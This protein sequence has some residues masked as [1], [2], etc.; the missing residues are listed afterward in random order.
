MLYWLLF[1]KLHTSWGPL[2]LFGYVTFR[3]ALA[4]LFAMLFTLL[5]GPAEKA[6][7]GKSKL[8]VVPTGAL[9]SLPFHLLVTEKPAVPDPI[10]HLLIGM[11]GPVLSVRS[12]GY[13]RP[14]YTHT[15]TMRCDSLPS[16]PVHSPI[17]LDTSLTSYW[18]CPSS[19]S[20]TC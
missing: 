18:G 16:F 7:Q 12:G 11:V 4:S 8:L 15:C 3:V 9:T 14:S 20:L 1:E 2:R 6:V 10:S 19:H 13:P 5:L 17:E